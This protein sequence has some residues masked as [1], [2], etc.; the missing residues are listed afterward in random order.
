MD[1]GGAEYGFAKRFMPAGANSPLKNAIVA[2]FNPRQVRSTAR[3]T[4]EFSSVLASHPCDD[5][6]R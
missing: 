5:A 1:G 3:K 2:F 6:A 4:D